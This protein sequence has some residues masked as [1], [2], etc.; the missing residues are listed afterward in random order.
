MVDWQ[1]MQHRNTDTQGDN[2]RD[3]CSN[4]EEGQPWPTFSKNSP[5]C[6]IS[7]EG[8]LGIRSFAGNVH[9]AVLQSWWDR[10]SWLSEQIRVSA[11]KRYQHGEIRDIK[12]TLPRNCVLVRKVM[13]T[14]LRT[15]FM[16]P[17]VMMTNRVVRRF[18]EE[19]A[20]R[21]VFRDDSGA[22]LIVKD[23]VQ[24]P[25]YDQQSSIVANIVQRT[26]SHGVEI[27]NRHYH[28]LAWSNSQMRDHGCYM[29]ASTLNRRTGDKAMTVEDMREWMGDFSSSKNVPKLMSRMGQCFTQAQ[30]TVS[31][32]LDE[33]CVEADVEGG[34]GH[35][36]THEPY[37]FSDGCGRISPSL[38]RRVALALQLDIVPS[39]Y[40]VRF[41]GFKGVLAI[42]PSLDLA[43]NGPKVVFRM[44]DLTLIFVIYSGMFWKLTSRGI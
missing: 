8:Q 32:T 7:R 44:F 14:P 11:M 23:F 39:C 30:P 4:T 29:Y 21:C 34:A 6:P 17:E 31:I 27:N 36:E 38:A 15:L 25:C 28:F 16:A 9:P 33:W 1:S 22:R 19:N 2:E 3:R 24:G 42:D 20:L 12:R 18:G 35:P 43:R 10:T 37:C 13:V 26:L 41:K 40:Q 5:H